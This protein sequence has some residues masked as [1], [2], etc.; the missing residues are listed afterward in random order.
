MTAPLSH[1]DL[2]A[3][4][5]GQPSVSNVYMLSL[6]DLRRLC[7]AVDG[8]HVDQH[9]EQASFIASLEQTIKTYEG[10]T[11]H[12]SELLVRYEKWSLIDKK[13]CTSE[14]LIDYMLQGRYIPLPSHNP[15]SGDYASRDAREQA[16]ALADAEAKGMAF[17][18]HG[19]HVSAD[20]VTIVSPPAGVGPIAAMRAEKEA[21][22]KTLEDIEAATSNVRFLA[23]RVRR[24]C[25]LCSVPVPEGDDLFIV[26]VAGTLL[27]SCCFA[28]SQFQARLLAQQHEAMELIQKIGAGLT[29]PAITPTHCKFAARGAPCVSHCGDPV[30][31]FA[32]GGVV[33]DRTTHVDIM[34]AVVAADLLRPSLYCD[35][36]MAL[37]ED[38]STCE[39]AAH[40]L[41]DLPQPIGVDINDPAQAAI[42][43]SL[44]PDSPLL[45]PI[46]DE[47]PGES[48]S[49]GMCGKVFTGH[50]LFCSDCS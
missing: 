37:G 15:T 49:C 10:R 2:I 39:K 3:K 22:R 34:P 13:E 23:N 29:T 42:V 41:D 40:A 7:F 36:G 25:D 9:A 38:C 33:I 47:A 18:V 17:L 45:R 20:H 26:S 35:H 30:C 5:V 44:P 43:A 11:P 1:D 50:G 19:V 8:E 12:M 4:T 32:S 31:M 27:G 24:M 46:T 21:A 28:L 6:D 48:M 14:S 16:S